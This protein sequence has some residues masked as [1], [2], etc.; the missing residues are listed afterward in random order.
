MPAPPFFPAR[1]AV[2]APGGSEAKNPDSRGFCGA[3]LWEGNAADTAAATGIEEWIYA[4][5]W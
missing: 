5:E 1:M 4:F 2:K 3:R